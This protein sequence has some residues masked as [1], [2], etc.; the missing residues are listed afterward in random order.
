M[1]RPA[2]E[3]LGLL[4]SRLGGVLVQRSFTARSQQALAFAIQGDEDAAEQ[5]VRYRLTFGQ[6]EDLKRALVALGR[7]LDA[8][9]LDQL[10]RESE[11]VPMGPDGPV[12]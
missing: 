2:L 4:F 5:L 7:M 10:M 11:R 6:A 8:R 9:M 12:T 1:N 3:R